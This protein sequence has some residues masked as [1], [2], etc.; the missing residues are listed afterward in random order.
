VTL[1]PDREKGII[2]GLALSINYDGNEN[3]FFVTVS[4]TSCQGANRPI[5][6]FVGV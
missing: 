2:G 6:R 3:N 4:E 1:E 5:D